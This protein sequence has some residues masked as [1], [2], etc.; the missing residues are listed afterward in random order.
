MEFQRF[1][2]LLGRCEDLKLSQDVRF[3]VRLA[4]NPRKKF[5]VFM[6]IIGLV[7]WHFRL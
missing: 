6:V 3:E 2:N 4:I 5:E 1:C 7:S